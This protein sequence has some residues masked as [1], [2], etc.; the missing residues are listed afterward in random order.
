[1]LVMS[2]LLPFR[3][4]GS[5][6]AITGATLTVVD[7][8]ESVD[9]ACTSK[10]RFGLVAMGFMTGLWMC[11]DRLNRSLRI[12]SGYIESTAAITGF[13]SSFWFIFVN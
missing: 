2:H 8:T 10:S 11:N 3:L 1:M 9:I 5:V 7:F 6:G 4:S 12:N 13:L